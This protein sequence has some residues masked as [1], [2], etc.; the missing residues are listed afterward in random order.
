MQTVGFW[1]MALFSLVDMHQCSGE[2]AISIC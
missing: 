2:D 1:D